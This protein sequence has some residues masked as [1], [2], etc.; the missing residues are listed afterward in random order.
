[1]AAGQQKYP[2]NINAKKKEEKCDTDN[3]FNT[4]PK[5]VK[6]LPLCKKFRKAGSSYLHVFVFWQERGQLELF[7]FS[8]MN[9]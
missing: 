6:K 1:M 2:S 9:F 3:L 7:W 5:N 8:H 4:K